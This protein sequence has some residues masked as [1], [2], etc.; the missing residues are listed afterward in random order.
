MTFTAT[1]GDPWVSVSATPTLTIKD[2]DLLAKPTGVKVS[3]DGAKARVDWTAVTSATGYTVQW[4]TSSA[5]TGTPSSATVTGQST[6]NHSI[7]TGLT[8]GTEYHFR[9]IAAATGYDDS[10]PSD[11]VSATPTT[12]NVDYDADND[13]LIE[14]SNLAQL[15]AIRWDLDGNGV[16]S[17]G[18]Q[19]NYDTAFPNAEDNMGCNESAVTIAS[20]D[21]GNP[22]CTGYELS[23]NLDFDTNTAGDRTDDTYYNSGNGW[24]PIGGVSGSTYTSNF[25]GNTYTI[26]NLF[27]D[28]SS[29]SYAGLFAYLNGGSGTT[30]QNLSLV[31]VDV[32]LNTSTGSS[33]HVGGLAGRVG[34]G[35]VTLEDSYTTGRVRAESRQRSR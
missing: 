5:F 8:S 23:A 3:L 20:N 4:S 13:G 27:I 31:N 25:N 11:S 32:T 33:V 18:N 26:S 22:A 29:G 12:G 28:R 1:T 24:D 17:S 34:D 15:N 14:V 6:T 16:A 19:T 21:T 35:G 9:V 2:D 30:V 7:T 10:A